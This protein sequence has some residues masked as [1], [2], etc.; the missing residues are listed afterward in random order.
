MNRPATI[1][2]SAVIASTMVRT[3]RAN[4]PGNSLRKT[5]QVRPSG[6]V[7]TSAMV[8]MLSVPTIACR[9]PPIG[10]RVERTGVRTGPAVKK[11][12]CASALAARGRA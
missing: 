2:G 10:Q 4:R 11:F 8:I 9:M 7:M 5:A 12:R 1:D 6:T 3:N